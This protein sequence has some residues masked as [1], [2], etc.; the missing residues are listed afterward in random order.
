MISNSDNKKLPAYIVAGA[1]LLLMAAAVFCYRLSVTW[2]H[3]AIY[4]FG[5]FFEK[6][7][8]FIE[9]GQ[10]YLRD[11]GAYA[12]LEPVYK[13]PPLSAAVMV[14][15]E[16]AGVTASTLA[17][18]GG[19]IEILLFVLP[20]LL[21]A[22]A[23]L[24]EKK[25]AAIWLGGLVVCATGPTLEENLTR[26]QLEPVLFACCAL[27]LLALLKQKDFLAGMLIGLAVCLKLYPAVLVFYFLLTRRWWALAG[28]MAISVLVTAYSVMVL[29]WAEHVFFVRDLLPVL[30]REYPITEAESVSVATWARALGMQPSSAKILSQFLLLLACGCAASR[31]LLEK[32][33]VPEKDQDHH[34]ACGFSMVLL[35]MLIGMPNPL[36][37]YQILLVIPLLVI[38]SLA[39]R[40]GIEHKQWPDA[41]TIIGVLLVLL[42]LYV[43]ASSTVDDTYYPASFA[44]KILISLSRTLAPFV[45]FGILLAASRKKITSSFSACRPCRPDDV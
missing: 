36:W 41:G 20:A 32:R 4:D 6:C 28:V 25:P 12:P 5:I 40:E 27:A 9:T 31:V 11:L 30:L 37:N 15:V 13:F 33:C 43:G 1:C 44:Q 26:L 45:L 16:R 29:G 19:W 3:V 39:L 24:P 21:L 10:L 8:H 2:Q 22:I 42:S 14:Q 23:L 34:V 18:I 17:N 7:R 35:A 38:S